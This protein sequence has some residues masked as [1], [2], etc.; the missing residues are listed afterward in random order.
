M[1]YVDW[2]IRGP[3]IATCNC[4]W[5][6][7]C[8]FNAPPTHGDCRAV[9]GTR[10]DEG[11]FGDVRLDGLKAACV[12]AWPGAIHEGH[13]EVLPIVDERATPEQ[14]E[15]LLKI[16]GGEE[17]EEFATIF[18][19]VAATTETVHEP[20]FRP[21]EFEVDEESRTGRFAVPGIIEAT[22]EPIRNPVTD[23]E[24][25]AK[26]V[27]PHGFEYAEAEYASSNVKTSGPIGNEWSDRH[28]HL[29]TL[30]L[31]PHGI[32]Q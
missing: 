21:I 8:Q 26:V 17:T 13:G 4:N 16:L 2:M 24:H 3:E 15:A 14:R 5:G 30:H 19:V 25:R 1:A 6:C 31:G 7:P 28:A 10:I 12:L 27:L 29:C 9:V 32:I 22:A 23:A 11:H 20:M 18:N